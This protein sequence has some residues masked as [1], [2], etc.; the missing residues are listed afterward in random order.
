MDVVE[1]WGLGI[2]CMIWRFWLRDGGWGMGSWVDGWVTCIMNYGV[3]GWS[4]SLVLCVFAFEWR[5]EE[6][7]FALRGRREG[8]VSSKYTA[9]QVHGCCRWY[10]IVVV[11]V[12]VQCAEDMDKVTQCWQRYMGTM[13]MIITLHI[14]RC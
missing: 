8:D 10:V 2:A 9:A 13:D 5:E 4:I 11:I 7:A 1:V 6:V 12:V 14:R 3:W